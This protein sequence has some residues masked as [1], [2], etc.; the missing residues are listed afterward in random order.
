MTFLLLEGSIC[1]ILLIQIL[2]GDQLDP[3]DDEPTSKTC[4][5]YRLHTIIFLIISCFYT[6]Q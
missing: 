2:V 6:D 1:T 4:V 5:Q 3:D